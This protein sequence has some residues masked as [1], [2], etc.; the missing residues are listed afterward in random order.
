MMKNEVQMR[1]F[2]QNRNGIGISKHPLFS[3]FWFTTTAIIILEQI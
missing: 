2:L 3:P 1:G